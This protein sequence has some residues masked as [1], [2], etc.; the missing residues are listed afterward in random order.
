MHKEYNRRIQESPTSEKVEV[1]AATDAR[2]RYVQDT[3][4]PVHQGED[5]FTD[6]QTTDL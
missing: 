2:P 4:Q 5:N 6:A 1:P 3:K